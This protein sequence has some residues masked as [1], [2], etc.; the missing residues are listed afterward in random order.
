MKTLLLALSV[1]CNTTVFSQ[2]LI[3]WDFEVDG[4]STLNPTFVGD[5]SIQVNPV[6][7]SNLFP[8]N[9]N[10]YSAGVS[11][12]QSDWASSV[13]NWLP[14]SSIHTYQNWIEFRF[15]V[16][17]GMYMN[18]DSISFW[19]KRNIIGP[20]RFEFRS[21][22]DSYT[23]PI[24]SI[25]LNQADTFWHKYQ[26]P[27]SSFTANGF[28]Q[29]TF[30]IYG[31]GA[32]SD[33]EGLFTTDSVAIF[34]SVVP[35]RQLHLR[36]CL[37]GPFVDST[38]LMRDD[39]RL[40]GLLPLMDPYGFFKTTTS[41][42][43][44]ASGDTAIVD[45]VVVELRSSENTQAVVRSMPALMRRDGKL[46]TV[47]GIHPL[48]TDLTTG[49]YYVALRHRNH[50]GVMTATPVNLEDTI[51]FTSGTTSVFG[52][53]ARK[54]VDTSWCLWDG[55]INQDKLVKYT[56]TQN[57]RDIVLQGI[58]GVVPTN[59]TGGYLPADVNMDGVVKYTGGEN[60]RDIILGNIGGIVPTNTR[61][62][63]VP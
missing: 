61:S 36:A 47:D 37:S 10:Y 17:T 8:L 43:L 5:I 14:D 28:E 62:S 57:D 45:W 51:D 12:N 39:L 52:Q 21:H 13:F 48:V 44:S 19:C 31:D 26:I 30:R 15:F 18:L 50:L 33:T 7:Y 56:G 11:G 16:D 54:Q 22:K 29:V 49:M 42:V 41:E 4:Q 40:Q 32:I 1:L 53:D 2:T 38:D 59:T 60:D 20:K 46:V 6:A 9:G 34:G 63:S 27:L 55:D 24:S 3:R 35:S 58:G 23:F 25:L